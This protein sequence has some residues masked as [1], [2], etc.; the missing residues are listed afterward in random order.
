M[1]RRR[2]VRRTRRG[3]FPAHRH[4]HRPQAKDPRPCRGADL[5]PACGTAC[6]GRRRDPPGGRRDERRSTPAR[7]AGVRRGRARP[8][9]AWRAS[10]GSGLSVEPRW[11][12]SGTG[13][14]ATGNSHLVSARRPSG[15]MSAAY[16]RPSGRIGRV[17]VEETRSWTPR[18]PLQVPLGP[19]EMD[20]RSSGWAVSASQLRR[21]TRGC[22][23]C[24]RSKRAATTGSSDGPSAKTRHLSRP[25]RNLC[26]ALPRVS[27]T[28]LSALSPL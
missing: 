27:R 25:Q 1:A 28:A 16:R 11:G 6:A 14:T 4:P 10:R 23:T 12:T 13:G 8:A 9:A 3:R 20:E 21:G 15:V 22:G 26:P 24:G 19:A 5:W 18:A 2:P 7:R 17:I